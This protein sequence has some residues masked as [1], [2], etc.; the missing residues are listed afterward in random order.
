[1]L[2]IVTEQRGDHFTLLLHGKVAGEWVPELERY[3]RSIQDAVP[4]AR[5]TVA[6]SDVSFIDGGGEKLVER[7]WREGTEFIVSGCLI[8]YLIDRICGT[9]NGVKATETIT[10]H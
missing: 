5:V 9:K 10:Q 3:W 8:R 7:M 6:F 2:R 1:M 4:G